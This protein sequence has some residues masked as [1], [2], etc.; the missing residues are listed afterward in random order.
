M[1]RAILLLASFFVALAGSAC[2]NPVYVRHPS[3]PPARA[4]G[5]EAL[6]ATARRAWPG[7]IASA[8]S[9]REYDAAVAGIV[10]E[11]ARK[12]GDAEER[13]AAARMRFDRR[14]GAWPAGWFLRLEPSAGLRVSG[15]TSVYRR[16]GYGVPVVAESGSTPWPEQ[17][18]STTPEGIFYPATALLTFPDDECAVLSI[19]NPREVAAVVTDHGTLPVAADYTT[20]YADLLARSKLGML[21]RDGF[22]MPGSAGRR[23][24]YLLEPY[25]PSKTPVVLV[26]GLASSPMAWRELTNEISGRPELRD[27]YQVWHY[28]YPTG[29]P[30]LY[31]GRQFRDTLD[32]ALA[33]LDPGGD[34]W[35]SSD[36]V[37]IG[38][39]MGGL[40]A[41]TAVSASGNRLW[42][43]AFTVPPDR[44][45]VSADDRRLL[46]E[47][48]IFR[49]RPYVT[50]AVFVMTPHAG[51]NTARGLLGS[52]GNRLV[53]LPAEYTALFS[54]VTAR[55]PDAITPGM[56]RILAAGGPTSVRALRPDHPILL[57]LRDVP[58]ADT[59]PFHLVVGDLGG[60]VGDG[61]VAFESQV[62]PGAASVDV[63][64][65]GHRELELPVV[66]EVLIALLVRHAQERS[67][68]AALHTLARTK[69]D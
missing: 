53:R 50:R 46:E 52:V 8:S 28:F 17:D 44:L 2:T 15:F 26:H 1:R 49:P 41:K 58:V 64:R 5:L 22:R 16:P 20:P 9:R 23:G 42:N 7:V 61:V 38:H 21:G 29:V 25:H 54:R 32:R 40:L 51:S 48:F 30:Y 33:E 12:P 10:I 18:A 69:C 56:R 27:R 31:A 11:L 65:A 13:A 37:L 6:V 60:H 43:A 4:G 39:S 68:P 36:V 34:D 59:V 67:A 35:A 63:V 55:N 24:L 62:L 45:D 47:I 3:P 57:A 66:N 19:V 14:D